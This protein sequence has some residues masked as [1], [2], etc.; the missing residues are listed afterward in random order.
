M[1]ALIFITCSVRLTKIEIAS[2][3]YLQ[4]IEIAYFP[5]SVNVS[6]KSSFLAFT[7]SL[8]ISAIA[9]ASF[10]TG[11]ASAMPS[12]TVCPAS[13]AASFAL[14]IISSDASLTVSF[15]C[16]TGFLSSSADFLKR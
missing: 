11:F 16:P 7:S 3:D 10:A 1:L 15:I 4:K 13:P 9:Y 12:L 5:L 2:I 14:I 6:F 8:A